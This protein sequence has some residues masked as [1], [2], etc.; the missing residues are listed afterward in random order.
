MKLNE[1]KN[2]FINN[3]TEVSNLSIKDKLFYNFYC[4]IHIKNRG[5]NFLTVII[6]CF[7]IVCEKISYNYCIFI[8]F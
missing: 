7:S 8:Q 6:S 1:I 5:L 2:A 4:C 3:R